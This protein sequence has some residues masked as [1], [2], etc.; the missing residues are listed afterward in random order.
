MVLLA[1]QRIAGVLGLLTLCLLDP[2]VLFAADRHPDLLIGAAS[3]LTD[4]F[5]V[6]GPQFEAA[7]GIHPV[8]SFGSTAQLARQMENGAPF[9]L[10]AA[11]DAEHIEALDAKG[12]LVPGSRAVY[13][14]GVL[15]LWFPA[16]G[17]TLRDLTSSRVRIIAIAKPELAPYGAAAVEALKR[18]GLWTEIEK[19]VVYAEN[20]SMARQYGASGNADAVLTAYAL[21]IHEQGSVVLLD[22]K[23]YSPIDQVLAISAASKQRT[24]AQRF[25]EYLRTGKGRDTL[26][27]FGY[28]APNN[29]ARGAHAK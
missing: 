7:S 5:R 11:A 20:I 16:S 25:S 9:D 1:L 22:P 14:K 29:P 12:L 15:A 26:A 18:A 17:K 10:I 4:A 2:R 6:I 28:G 23:L 8:F 19:E 3:N 13:A 21:V 24:A 27:S